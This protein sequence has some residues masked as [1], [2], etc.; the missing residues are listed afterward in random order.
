MSN[1]TQVTVK[2][3]GQLSLLDFAGVKGEKLLTCFEST[4]K[5][6]DTGAVTQ[7]IRL[8]KKSDISTLTGRS[9]EALDSYVLEARDAMKPELLNLIG[10][11]VQDP[12]WTATSVRATK[13]KKGKVACTIR[14]DQ[15]I[16]DLISDEKIAASLKCTVEE[17]Q[18]MRKRQQDAV[19][20]AS[21]TPVE[22][23]V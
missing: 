4:E 2:Q 11:M 19:K 5:V 12:H 14:L 8:A 6:S 20:A 7:I 1:D 23:K 21:G 16:R 18:A 13:S 15:V 3:K 17:V 22:S 10:R 9:K